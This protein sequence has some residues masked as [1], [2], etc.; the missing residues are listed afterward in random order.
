MWQA[1]YV[2]EE[3]EGYEGFFKLRD[4]VAWRWLWPVVHTVA[5]S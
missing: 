5:G 3:E 1:L 2:T 4:L